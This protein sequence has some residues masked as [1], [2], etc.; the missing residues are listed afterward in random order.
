M[1][2][3]RTTFYRK[4]SPRLR[5][6]GVPAWL[7]SWERKHKARDCLY[8]KY[9]DPNN[10]PKICAIKNAFP[11]GVLRFQWKHL[12]GLLEICWT[13]CQ[14]LM[15][16]TALLTN[17]VSGT[18]RPHVVALCHLRWACQWRPWLEVSPNIDDILWLQK[19]NEGLEVSF[20]FSQQSSLKEGYVYCKISGHW[21]DRPTLHATQ[22]SDINHIRSKGRFPLCKFSLTVKPAARTSAKYFTIWPV[23]QPV[24]DGLLFFNLP[25]TST[26]C[27][28]VNLANKSGLQAPL[29]GGCKPKYWKKTCFVWCLNWRLSVLTLRILQTCAQSFCRI[30]YKV[31]VVTLVIKP[32]VRCQHVP[33][34]KRNHTEVPF[35]FLVRKYQKMVESRF[36]EFKT[37]L[38]RAEQHGRCTIAF[39]W[40]NCSS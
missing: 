30:D 5:R 19:S 34:K 10:Q 16:T 7:A 15:T 9:G 11:V 35:N 24:R 20:P 13:S 33:G 18:V 31:W 38:R 4:S 14:K 26:T 6:P 28:L 39:L 17:H 8:S 40:I 22:T 1:L 21:W 32:V 3:R 37:K 36:P 12:L 27:Y 23:W 25:S 2:F 29:H